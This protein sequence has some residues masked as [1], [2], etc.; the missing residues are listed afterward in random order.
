M[1]SINDWKREKILET[2]NLN[3]WY[4]ASENN[5]PSF[6][7]WRLKKAINAILD[8]QAPNPLGNPDPEAIPGQPPN[9]QFNV[10]P[11]GPEGAPPAGP[12]GAPPPGPEGAPPAG[13]EGAPPP[14]G[15][16]TGPMG[17]DDK[18]LI[19]SLQP[20][21]GDKPKDALPV[22]TALKMEAKKAKEKAA[23]GKSDSGEG[24]KTWLWLCLDAWMKTKI[25]LPQPEKTKGPPGPPPGSPPPGTGLTTTRESTTRGSTTR[26]STGSTARGS[27]TRGSTGSTARNV[28]NA[29][30][31]KN[32]KNPISWDKQNSKT[33][34]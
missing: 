2:F 21:L 18:A 7:D 14:E 33:G 29:E 26:G 20:I 3:E 28:I 10:P 4:T 22:S 25:S 15:Q 13:P 9:P 31:R 24:L 1:K 23:H 30:N 6:N 16:P 12:E 5:M 34:K 19:S 8:E 27:T 11:P 17:G 32:R